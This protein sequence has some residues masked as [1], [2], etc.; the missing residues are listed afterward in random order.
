MRCL[1][2]GSKQSKLGWRTAARPRPSP[3]SCTKSSRASW[4]TIQVG[5][6][7]SS[8][9]KA[10]S[11]KLHKVLQG[12]L[13][14]LQCPWAEG[15]PSLFWELGTAWEPPLGFLSSRTSVLPF[16]TLRLQNNKNTFLA[17]IS[18]EQLKLQCHQVWIHF[19]GLRSPE[20]AYLWPKGELAHAFQMECPLSIRRMPHHL[21]K[22]VDINS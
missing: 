10:K 17:N 15:H 2:R 11:V 4:S 3:W 13:V 12:I 22:M 16:A 7:Y 1:S 18:T 8:Q 19:L 20:G 14:Y 5:L 6:A 9:T 21:G